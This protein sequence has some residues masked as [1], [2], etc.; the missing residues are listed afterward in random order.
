MIEKIKWWCVKLG[1]LGALLVCIPVMW[2]IHQG[3]RFNPVSYYLWTLLSL[4]C[5]VVL[6]RAGKGGVTMMGGYVLSDF[7]V[8]TYAYIKSGQAVFGKFEWFIVSLTL[9][10]AILYVWCESKKNYTPSVIVNAIAC[11]VAGIPQIMD[12]FHDPYSMGFMICIMYMMVSVLSYY[13]EQPSLN[14][15]LI[16]GVSIVYWIIMIVGILIGRAKT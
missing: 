11:C 9:V 8:A 7:S 1:G 4:V 5:T 12:T 10:C 2:K 13:G 14:G 16:P 15:R 3:D 6:V